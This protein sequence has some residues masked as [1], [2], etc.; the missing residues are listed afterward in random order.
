MSKKKMYLRL[1]IHIV[2]DIHQPLHVSPEGTEGGNS[3]KV[4]WMGQNTNLHSVWDSYL[5]DFQQLSY[6][7]Y[8]KTI[9]HTTAAQ[10][11][12]LQKQ[13]MSK[14]LFESYTI[15]QQILNEVK[16]PSPKING[17]LYN[18]QHI[19]TINEQLVKGGVHLAGILNKIFG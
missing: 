18:F 6:T 10:R 3:V 11:K 15:S 1:L 9:N 19:Q 7:E 4:T 2:G 5:I 8:T 17:Y 12:K 16:E 14:W 13:P